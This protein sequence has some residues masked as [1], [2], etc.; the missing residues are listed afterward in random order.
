MNPHL[1]YRNAKAI[2]WTRIDMLLVIYEAAIEALD[3]GI[4]IIES[5]DHSELLHAQIDAQRKILLIAEG[6]SIDEDATAV[7]IMNL[8]VFVLDQIQTDKLEQW[9]TSL[10]LI[11]T[12][13]EGFQEIADDARELERTGQVPQLE[14]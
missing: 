3:H 4:G 9:Q 10:R 2:A 5:Q 12:L 11:E 13:H 7:H 6:L 1:K 8:C 14:T